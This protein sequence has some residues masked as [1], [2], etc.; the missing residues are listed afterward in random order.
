[1]WLTKPEV[2][3][4]T[5]LFTITLVATLFPRQIRALPGLTVKKWKHLRLEDLHRQV[6]WLERMNGD[7]YA[8]LLWALWTASII[9]IGLF[10]LSMISCAASFYFLIRLTNLPSSMPF[11]IFGS[12]PLA[13]VLGQL[14]VIYGQLKSLHHYDESMVKLK[15]DIAVLAQK[16]GVEVP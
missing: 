8:L 2:I 12:I 6:R 4:T 14:T 3:Y 13:F 16:L 5:A 7:S 15:N 1:M 11:V 10:L 9:L